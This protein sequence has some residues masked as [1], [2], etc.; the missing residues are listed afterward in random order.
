MLVKQ[1]AKKLEEYAA[2]EAELLKELEAL[3]NE[4]ELSSSQVYK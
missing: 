4:R 1:Q 3:K 2:R